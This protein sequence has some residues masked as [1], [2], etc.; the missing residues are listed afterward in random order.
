[1]ANPKITIDL[2]CLHENGGMKSYF[3]A[4]QF[5]ANRVEGLICFRKKIDFIHFNNIVSRAVIWN[6]KAYV[7]YDM[8]LISTNLDSPYYARFSIDVFVFIDLLKALSVSDYEYLTENGDLTPLDV[9]YYGFGE[10]AR[11]YEN[12]KQTSLF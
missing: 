5:Y 12:P 10:I 2:N 6:G 8:K 1:M 9:A 11:F 4:V 3:N 7:N